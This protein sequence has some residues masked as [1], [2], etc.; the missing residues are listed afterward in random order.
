[1]NNPPRR[2]MPDSI[3]DMLTTGTTGFESNHIV[4]ICE[5][6]FDL[7]E[8]K[9]AELIPDEWSMSANDGDWG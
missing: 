6:D 5:G 9:V 1:M 2:S 7:S 4:D 3:S 8:I